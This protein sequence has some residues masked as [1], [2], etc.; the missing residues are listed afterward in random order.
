MNI[1]SDHSRRTGRPDSE[2]GPFLRPLRRLRRNGLRL[3]LAMCA[4][5]YAA[6]IPV[7]KA[8]VG[9]LRDVL[10]DCRPGE[11]P[12]GALCG[13][14]PVFEDRQGRTG[15]KIE[16]NVVV[17]PALNR[18]P[19]PDPVFF[20]AGGPG[21]AAT[22]TGS[23]FSRAFRDVRD[24]RDL[25]FVDQR[26]TGK[27][28]GLHCDLDS[29]DLRSGLTDE[30][31][32]DRLRQ[33]LEG[34][35]ADPR[36]Y[37]TP[38]AMDDLD[39][40]RST[41]GYQ[42]INLWGGSYGTRA[43]LVYL[44]RHGE[45]VRS[46]V[47]DGAVP[48]G[49]TLPA[50]F[51]EDNQR[52]LELTLA[53]CETDDSCRDR[54]PDLRRKLGALLERLE[55][56]PVPVRV[57]HPRTGEPVEFDLR[58]SVFLSALRGSLYST[59]G[60]SLIPM[61]IEKAHGGDFAGVVALAI[62]EEAVPVDFRISLGMFFSVICAEDWPWFDREE[63]RAATPVDFRDES[64]P[65]VWDG[66]CS[67]WPHVPLVRNYHEPVRSEAPALLLSGSLDPVTPPRWGDK[68]LHGLASARH[69]VVPGVAHGTSFSGCVPSLISDFIRDGSAAQLDLAC[70]KELKRSPFFV[71][72]AGPRMERAE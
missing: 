59:E 66:V 17:F 6:S 25:V 27:S 50:T 51:P 23:F 10:K 12:R 4:A 43:A 41:L 22:V 49:M 72:N 40:V 56:R 28:N 26:G 60:A 5:A 61:M 7:A 19:R 9:Q 54:F 20:L 32:I 68:A 11:G 63:W 55:R 70:V 69:V 38:V 18:D 33:C 2:C 71:T 29:D 1:S 45:R 13:R 44:R 65:E 3:A 47:L 67:F 58:R 16:L 53:A 14:V 8:D 21:Q 31:A 48:L 57:K 35:D 15:R 62:A 52:A 36:H 37:T 24:H 42:R 39:E 64:I 30:H 34:Y 46:V